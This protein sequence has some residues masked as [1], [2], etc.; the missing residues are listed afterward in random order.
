MS[1]F[2]GN[3]SYKKFLV[4]IKQIIQEAQV[5]AVITVNQQMLLLYWKIGNEILD[6]Q[7]T[8]GWGDNVIGQLSADLKKT[9]PGMKGFSKRN[10]KYMRRFARVYSDFTIG[11]EPLAQ[12][13]WYH[14]ITLLQKCPDK[15]ERLWY[16]QKNYNNFKV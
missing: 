4:E 14:N 15:K 6:R 10:L 8:A 16:A 12:I 7:K 3:E 9:F 1:N 5:K 13:T 11:Q 2:S